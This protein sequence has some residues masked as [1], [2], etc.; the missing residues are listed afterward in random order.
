MRM[1]IVI[2]EQGKGAHQM[3]YIRIPKQFIDR[4]TLETEK[5]YIIEFP[6]L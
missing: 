2:R 1:K 3:Y 4:E 6:E 5:E